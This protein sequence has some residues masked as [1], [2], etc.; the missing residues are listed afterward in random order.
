M[1]VHQKLFRT[2]WLIPVLAVVAGAVYAVRP[3][4]SGR[5]AA[6]RNAATPGSQRGAR[7]LA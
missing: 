4:R 1:T 7:H 3:R 6:R 2:A 5:D